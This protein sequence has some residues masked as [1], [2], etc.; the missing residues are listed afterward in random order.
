MS[1]VIYIH[2]ANADADNFNYFTLKLP[3][4]DYISPEYSM[5]DDPYDVVEYIKLRRKRKL[6]TSKP[7]ILV[8]HSF[9]GI[10]ASWYASV[11][12]NDVQALVT[13][14]TPWEGTP[15]ARIFGYF[16]RNAKV[17]QTTRPDSEFLVLLKEKTFTGP[18]LNIVCT[19][20]ANPVAGLGG[21]AN[22]GMI[23]VD[24]QSNTPPN[25]AKS[26]NTFI[27]AGHSGVLLNN[28]VTDLLQDIIEN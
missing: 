23:T 22:D 3:E 17:F 14:A 4:H 6:D 19:R 27:E 26:K 15:V 25:F 7:V 8:G 18:H 28:I 2:G 24:S 10:L 21:K 5:D 16:W 11:Y 1:Q 12:P 9:G 20:G 13:I